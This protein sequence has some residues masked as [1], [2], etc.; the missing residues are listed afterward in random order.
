MSYVRKTPVKS[1]CAVEKTLHV[2]AG[3]WKP[4]ILSELLRTPVVRLKTI[5]EGLPE[6]TKRALTKQLQELIDDN[7]IQKKEYDVYPKKTEYSLTALGKELAPVFEV[8]KQF[9]NKL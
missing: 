6:A 4:A 7:L 8:M 9:G 2:I 5:Q 1:D 3:K